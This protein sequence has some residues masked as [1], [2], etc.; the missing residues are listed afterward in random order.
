MI[1][2][3]RLESR[4]ENQESRMTEVQGETSN[5]RGNRCSGHR[6]RGSVAGADAGRGPGSWRG[7]EQLPASSDA[8]GRSGHAGALGHPHR[9]ADGA[10]DGV[11]NPGVHDREGSG[12]RGSVWHASR[13]ETR[14]KTRTSSPNR[15]RG[16]TPTPIRPTMAGRDTGSRALSTTLS[17]APTRPGRKCRC[18]RRRS[19]IRRTG[20][21]LR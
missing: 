2:D 5:S 13:A 15:M 10:A 18:G 4:I 7:Q 6:D 21:C 16:D 3:L 11:W 8:M 20:E 12:C 14:T 17:G 9:H 19:S 1:S